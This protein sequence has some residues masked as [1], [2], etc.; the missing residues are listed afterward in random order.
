MRISIASLECSVRPSNI[1]GRIPTIFT[2]GFR[3]SRIIES[4]FSSCTSPRSDRYSHCT[5]TITP[6]EATSALIVSSPSEGG[7]S[8]ST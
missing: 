2:S 6:S 1:V 4:V 3:F 8:I 5:G 7:V